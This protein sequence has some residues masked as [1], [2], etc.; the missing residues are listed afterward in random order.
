MDNFP[1]DYMYWREAVEQHPGI[2]GVSQAQHPACPDQRLGDTQWMI[3]IGLDMAAAVTQGV[4][5]RRRAADGE[6]VMAVGA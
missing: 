5:P 6:H 1:D 3:E 4:E 2:A